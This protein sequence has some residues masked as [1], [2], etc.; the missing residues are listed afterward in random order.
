MSAWVLL[1]GLA[2]ES[3]H[4]GAFRMLLRD[5]AAPGDLV[6]ALD[7]PGTGRAW[8]QTSPAQVPAIA[9]AARARV[10]A[11]GVA[12]P[13]VLV[14][15]SLGGMVALQWA[16]SHPQEVA[17][18]ALI[19]TS[20]RGH[21]RP[22]QRLRPSAWMPLA[23]LLRPGLEPWRREQ[24]VLKL[25]SRVHATDTQLA[26]AWARFT[27]RRPLTRANVIRQLWAA[28]RF[29]MPRPPPVAGLLLASAG[30]DLVCPACSQAIAGAWDWQLRV[31]PSAGHDLALDD[32]FWV[33]QRLL[34]WRGGFGEAHG[35]SSTSSAGARCH[36]TATKPP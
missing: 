15:M 11:L 2:R 23:G 6:I 22:W 25:T 9:D 33:L 18:C 19:N 14:G 27:S 10:H 16:A 17:G 8:R 3:R 7:L 29:T 12:G 34:E 31:H 4:W 1:R 36:R 13:V 32:P 26:R 28:A 21:S 20:L 5:H 35:A 24:R 30:D